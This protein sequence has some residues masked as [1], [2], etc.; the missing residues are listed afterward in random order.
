LSDRSLQQYH[1]KTEKLK[2]KKRL[3]RKERLALLAGIGIAE[4]NVN[5]I[6]KWENARAD[7]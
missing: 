3:H 6:L 1:F 4:S 7:K 2:K 5:N